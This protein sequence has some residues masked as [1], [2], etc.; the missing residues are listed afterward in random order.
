M[1]LDRSCCRQQL[2]RSLKNHKI[3][4]VAPLPEGVK[5]MKTRFVF[6]KK[7]HS[8]GSVARYK[9]RLVVQGFLQGFVD[10]TYAPV[11]D[12]SIVRAALSIAV[13]RG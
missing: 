3:W 2:Q 8:D 11:V 4:I 12:F 1:P 6:D 7:I 5:P 10:M 9:A 13:Q